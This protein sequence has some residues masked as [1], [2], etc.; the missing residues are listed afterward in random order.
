MNCRQA[1]DWLLQCEDPRPAPSGSP[2]LA[3]HLAGCEVCRLLT[4]KVRRL[5]QAWRPLPVP[6][7][8]DRARVAFLNRLSRPAVLPIQ[9]Q[10]VRSRRFATPR[11]AVAALVFLAVGMGVWLLFPAPQAHAAP[12]LV[13]RLVDWNLKLTQAKSPEER[14]RIYAELAPQLKDAVQKT[15]MPADDRALAESLLEN[16]T[17]L[18]GNDDPV[19]EADRFND[20]ADKLLARMDSATDGGDAGKVTQLARLY[21]QVADRGISANMEKAE[22]AAP[23]DPRIEQ[24]LEAVAERHDRHVQATAA[25]VQRAPAPARKEVRQA[26]ELSAKQQKQHKNKNQKSKGK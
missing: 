19:A 25:L 15:D 23:A 22:A 4:G 8:A 2:E 11:W 18:A 9:P 16:G 24:K 13:D 1:Q 14:N 12:E 20:V 21:S 10:R 17:W 26:H 6:A 5:E 7:S 3:E